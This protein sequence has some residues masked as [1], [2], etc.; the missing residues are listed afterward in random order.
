M[1]PEEIRKIPVDLPGQFRRHMPRYVVGLGLLAIYQ[2]AQWWF[3]LR[4]QDAINAATAGES[5][6]TLRLGIL[7]I[8]VA[9]FAFLVRVFSRVIIFNAGRIGEYELRSALLWR[10]HKL[11]TAFYQKMPAGEIMS[12]ATNDH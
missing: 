6:K 12:R 4:M 10:L 7:L 2:I 1:N 9:L 11:G 5:E 3:D 8:V